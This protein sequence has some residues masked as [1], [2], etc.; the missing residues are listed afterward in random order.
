M[1]MKNVLITWMVR[2]QDY[3]AKKIGLVSG[4]GH[5]LG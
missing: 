3:I 4:V 2:N 1:R 5:P